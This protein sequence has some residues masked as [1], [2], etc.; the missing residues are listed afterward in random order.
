VR[1]LLSIPGIL[2]LAALPAAGSQAASSGIL[3]GTTQISFGC[4]GPV[5]PSGPG[6]NPWHA[7]PHARFS[8]ARR[9][10][11]TRAVVV[12]SGVDAHF[13]LRVEAGTYVVT[14]LPGRSTHGGPRLV[15]RVRAGAATVVLV[16]FQG[17]PQME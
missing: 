5:D 4:P 2:A 14:P 13:R 3:R 17:Y 15:A 12:T 10:S 9:A 1:R 7:F 6:C 11:T 16:R 8:V